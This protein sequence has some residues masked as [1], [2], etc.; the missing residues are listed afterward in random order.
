M[1]RQVLRLLFVT[2]FAGLFA[3]PHTALADDKTSDTHKVIHS[4]KGAKPVATHPKRQGK[5][6]RKRQ[7]SGGYEKHQNKTITMTKEESKIMEKNN[8]LDWQPRKQKPMDAY[9]KAVKDIDDYVS[10]K[11]YTK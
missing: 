1:I 7:K 3:M 4:G 5:K 10:N 6:S 9:E 2:L 8:R 11:P